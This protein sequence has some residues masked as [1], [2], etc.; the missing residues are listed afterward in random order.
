MHIWS[1]VLPENS[2]GIATMAGIAVICFEMTAALFHVVVFFSPVFP[3]AEELWKKRCKQSRSS[4]F[5]SSQKKSILL[6][7]LNEQNDKMTHKWG[8][9]YCTRIDFFANEARR[10]QINGLFIWIDAFASRCFNT[11][12]KAT[13]S[14]SQKPLS[15]IKI[16]FSFMFLK[17]RPHRLKNHELSWNVEECSVH[18][19]DDKGRNYR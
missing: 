2:A 19:F 13:H 10:R 3:L 17:M 8:N 18:L 4:K 9:L 11:L 14:I 5:E 12:K 15:Q 1:L 7:A 16:G 6:R